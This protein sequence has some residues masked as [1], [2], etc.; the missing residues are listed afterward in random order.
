MAVYFARAETTSFVKIGFARN[1]KSRMYLLQAGCPYR[2]TLAR[3]ADG[4][5]R[6]EGAFHALF[7]EH[8]IDRD[9]FYWTPDMATANAPELQPV[10]VPIILRKY[11]KGQRGRLQ[12]LADALGIFPSAI[13]QWE[14][15]PAERVPAI[16]SATAIPRHD[17]RP[18]LYGPP[19]KKQRRAA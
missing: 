7:A 16:E 6:T 13:L 11:L 15:V 2:L 9:W 3:E 1:V 5:R 10:V 12:R 4:D 19:P 17:L 14:K 8:H 18:D